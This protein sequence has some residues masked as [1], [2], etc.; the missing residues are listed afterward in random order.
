MDGSRS[1]AK[2]WGQL[3]AIGTRVTL[4][5]AVLMPKLVTPNVGPALK[6]AVSASGWWIAGIEVTVSPSVTSQQYGLIY[7]GEPGAPQT[8]LSTVPQDLVLDRMYIHGQT[9][10]NLSRCVAL[11]AGRTQ[12]SASFIVECHGRASTPRRLAAGTARARTRS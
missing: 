2:P 5:D 1:G 7:L 4:A 3:A 6:T 12:I 10:T 11:N 8:S 9:N